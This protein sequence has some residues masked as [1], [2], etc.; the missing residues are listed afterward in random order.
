MHVLYLITCNLWTWIK[1]YFS[2]YIFSKKNLSDFPPVFT[3]LWFARASVFAVTNALTIRPKSA[4]LTNRFALNSWTNEKRGE[5]GKWNIIQI[6]CQKKINI[7][8][9]TDKNIATLSSC[10][11]YFHRKLLLIE[12]IIYECVLTVRIATDNRF[13][14]RVFLLNNIN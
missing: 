8:Y 1:A 12:N 7:K 14:L 3:G 10:F 13:H 11:Q 4:S 9:G 2:P 6:F 5:N